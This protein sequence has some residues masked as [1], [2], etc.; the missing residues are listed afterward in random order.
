M[1]V[2]IV[3]VGFCAAATNTRPLSSRVFATLHTCPACHASPLQSTHLSPA[4][5]PCKLSP[6]SRRWLCFRF[7]FTRPVHIVS[8][9]S[10]DF[11]RFFRHPL[12]HKPSRVRCAHYATHQM[13]GEQLLRYNNPAASIC[14]WG[15]VLLRV[16]MVAHGACPKLLQ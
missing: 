2:R 10:R 15:T 6:L 5:A 12:Q 14:V 9:F 11:F 3:R 4:H 8:V 13:W 16:A 7:P 1:D